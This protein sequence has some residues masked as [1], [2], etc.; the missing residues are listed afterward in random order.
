MQKKRSETP[1]R[2]MHCHRLVPLS[3]FERNLLWSNLRFIWLAVMTSLD[4][5]RTA[6]RSITS[7]KTSMEFCRADERI[8]P[9]VGTESLRELA[10]PAP[11]VGIALHERLRGILCS[12]ISG[13]KGK[14]KL[15]MW[16]DIAHAFCGSEGCVSPRWDS[17]IPER[18]QREDGRLIFDGCRYIRRQGRKN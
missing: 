6:A 10:L 13:V 2:G 14:M 1:A 16:Q 5:H 18:M 12:C 4:L 15:F 7:R 8:P 17:G 11:S 3:F 9:R